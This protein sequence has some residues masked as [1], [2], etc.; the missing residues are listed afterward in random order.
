MVDYEGNP[1]P[2]WMD[3]LMTTVLVANKLGIPP[4]QLDDMDASYAMGAMLLIMMENEA[5]KR[6]Q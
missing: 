6:T 3:E 1:L 5:G 4:T 2:V